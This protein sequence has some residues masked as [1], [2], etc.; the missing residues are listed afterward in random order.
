M[1]SRGW[2]SDL[3]GELVQADR[4]LAGLGELDRRPRDPAACCLSP[5]VSPRALVGCGALLRFWRG[6]GPGSR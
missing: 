1:V 5:M 2:H 4:A 3:G 6:V